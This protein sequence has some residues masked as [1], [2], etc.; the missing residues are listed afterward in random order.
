MGVLTFVFQPTAS[1]PLRINQQRPSSRG[2]GGGRYRALHRRLVARE[3]LQMPLSQHNR[4]Y[5]DLP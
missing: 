1:L 5:E 4:P 2:D 3:P